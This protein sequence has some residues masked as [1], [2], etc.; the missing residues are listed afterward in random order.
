MFKILQIPHSFLSP[1]EWSSSLEFKKIKDVLSNLTPLNE[2]FE[3]ALAQAT[4]AFNDNI[5]KDETY[6]K[7]MMLVVDSHRKKFKLQREKDLKFKLF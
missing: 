6:Y 2:C 7:E 5:T 1:P 4:S 3:R